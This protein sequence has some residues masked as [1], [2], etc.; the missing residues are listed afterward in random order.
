MSDRD[1]SRENDDRGSDLRRP[2]PPDSQ[3]LARSIA[4][5]GYATRRKAEEM[6]RAGQVT[7]DGRR[8]HD[9]SM[10]V[11][12]ESEILIDG[13]PMVEAIRH[14]FAFHKPVGVAT[15][16]GFS[17][18]S[19]QAVEFFPEDIPGLRPAG[20][21]DVNTSGLMLVSNDSPWNASAAGGS[22]FEKEYL[23]E[24]SA[25][26]TPLEVDVIASG[27]Q[28]AK[29]GFMKPEFVAVEKPNPE[30]GTVTLRLVLVE[31]KVRQ[32]RNL[33]TALRH[34][35]LSVHRLRIGPVALDD[36]PEGQ[37]RPLTRAQIEAVRRGRSDKGRSR[38]GRPGR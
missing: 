17:R 20:R 3:G 6:V 25:P 2:Y 18:R 19:R 23:I 36:L 30:R 32:I 7:V 10:S 33:F 21:L 29:V 11:T 31:G 16:P 27:M 12:P 38:A 4:K 1:D 37:L 13:Q 24:V 22:G 14:Y 9:P 28:I 34:R 35:V 8:A 5:A 15:G 26:V